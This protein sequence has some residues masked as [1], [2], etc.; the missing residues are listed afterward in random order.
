MQEEP[1]VDWIRVGITQFIL[2]KSC[3]V[4]FL[5]HCFNGLTF[6]KEFSVDDTVSTKQ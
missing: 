6:W 5:V 3:S 1:I 2:F 4:T